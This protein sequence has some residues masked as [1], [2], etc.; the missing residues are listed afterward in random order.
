MFAALA[1][2]LTCAV[3]WTQDASSNIKLLQQAAAE[4]VTSFKSL[5]ILKTGDSQ[6]NAILQAISTD[7]A[8]AKLIDEKIAANDAAGAEALLRKRIGSNNV[9]VRSA[10]KVDGV[11]SWTNCTNQTAASG[12]T[13]M[14]CTTTCVSILKRC[15]GRFFGRA[16]G[17]SVF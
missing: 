13:V 5:K 8:F 11:M 17:V 10:R 7:S 14:E 9:T 15:N 12:E 4:G 1:I 16:T 3:A 2:L 6:D